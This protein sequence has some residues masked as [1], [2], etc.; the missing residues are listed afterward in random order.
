[1]TKYSMIFFLK[2]AVGFV[3]CLNALLSHAQKNEIDS[4]R[5]ILPS[6]AAVDK[7]NI[8][9]RIGTQ[10]FYSLPDSAIYYFNKALSLS[11]TTH[12]DTFSAKSLSK[13]GILHYGS[14]DYPKAIN[15][16]FSALK[17]F[18]RLQDKKRTMLC[19]QHLGM[20]Y[21]EQGMYDKALDYA[22]QSLEICITL[23]DKYSAA[24]SLGNIGS[25]YF[26]QSDYDQA[27]DYFLQAL[28]IAEDIKHQQGIAD[29]LNNV[30]LIYE[31]KKDFSKALEYH[32]RSL[33]LAKEMGDNRDIAASYHNIGLVYRGMEKF[34]VAIQYLDSCIVLAKEGDDKFY[35]KEAYNTLASLYADIGRFEKAYQTRLLYAQINDTL[36]SQ[37]NKKQFAEMNTRYET[38][39][40]DNQISLLNKDREKQRVIR[41]GF[42]GGFA[43]VLLFAVVFFAQRNRIK[44][45]KQRSDELLLNILPEETAEELKV[46]GYA[47]AKQYDNVTVLFTDFVGF[48]IAGER[49]TP[50][51]LVHELD[52][53]FKAFDEIITKY[54]IEKI[55]TIGDAYMA[56]CGLPTYDQQHAEKVVSAAL[57]INQFI[58]L[59]RQQLGDR[60][61]GV[62]IGIH[63]GPVVAGI[64]G[65]KK[66][67]YDI[68]GDTV[69][70]AARMESSGEE[71]KVNISETT[72]ELIKDKFDCSYRGEITAKNKGEM[73]MYFVESTSS[74]NPKLNT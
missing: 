9:Y 50:T 53:C 6:A 20:A 59:R 72:Y 21:N 56:V 17:I 52:T 41:N 31:N 7:M 8:N 46:K 1:M 18:E 42:V 57:E 68:W 5:N 35:L 13:I 45:G 64:V 65:V 26:A 39:K 70:V 24:V 38:E 43:I 48:T 67:A 33:T 44:K 12:N 11:R 3:L 71:G 25:V 55:K 61:F 47:E 4:L 15:N 54:D 34:H 2:T 74:M 51:E 40:K 19:M 14:G 22:Q 36:M 10:F 63:S 62:R 37:E 58:N 16:L 32:L 73:R 49:M 30:A 69:N 28:N 27:L 29:A 66:F 23:D 60:T